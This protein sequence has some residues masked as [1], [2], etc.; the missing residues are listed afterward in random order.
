MHKKI[1]SAV[2]KLDFNDIR[3]R[4]FNEMIELSTP[5]SPT[6]W[7]KLIGMT[8]GVVNNIHGKTKQRPSFPYIINVSKVTK[9]PVEYF[10]WGEEGVSEK[11]G[12]EESYEKLWKAIDEINDKLNS[13]ENAPG[14]PKKKTVQRL[15]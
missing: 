1:T 4:I 6:A 15:K 8:M 10:L 14:E 9:K 11:T 2:D 3:V 5:Y 12:N 13:I 7:G